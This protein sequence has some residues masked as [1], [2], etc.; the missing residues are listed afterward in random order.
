M[1]SAGGEEDE[2]HGSRSEET[3]KQIKEEADR[4]AEL[5]RRREGWAKAL[6]RAREESRSLYGKQYGVLCEV[7]LTE[8]E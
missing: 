5:A 7:G 8:A 1:E 2:D 4:S 6:E 3:A